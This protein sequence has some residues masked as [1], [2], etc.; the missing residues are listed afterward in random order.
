VP[1]EDAAGIQG[2]KDTLDSHAALFGADDPQTL[3]AVNKLAVAI[4]RAGNIDG[5]VG[6]LDQ[7]LDLASTRG[8]EHPVH[9]DLLS[10]LG[11]I[12]FEERHLEQAGVI[13]R[14]VL[15]HRI[16]HA[17]V[18]HPKSLE[19]KASLAAVLFELGQEEEAAS[20]EKEAFESARTHLG[21]THPV[22][23]VLAWNQALSHEHRGDLDSARS[24]IVAELA[25]L[26]AEDASLL[27][28][29]QKTIQ[30]M[31]SQRLQWNAASAC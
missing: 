22:T 12:M 4:W 29:D 15:E 31:L 24:I 14:E 1:P 27:E 16:R 18:N 2:L 10:T 20:L 25:W 17:G 28:A 9:S 5:A 30:A 7:A 19:A 11:E 21:K 8:L 26:L 23:C 6:L 13:H 3:A